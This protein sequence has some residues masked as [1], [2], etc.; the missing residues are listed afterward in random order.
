MKPR[1]IE[2]NKETLELV[3]LKTA[4]GKTIHIST[5]NTRREQPSN[6]I[7]HDKEHATDP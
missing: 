7:P 6:L 3:G 2:T 5:K 4:R 1:L